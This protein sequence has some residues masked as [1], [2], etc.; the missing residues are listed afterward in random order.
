MRHLRGDMIKFYSI[1]IAQLASIKRGA[2]YV[3]PDG[4]VVANCRL[5]TSPDPCVS[6]AYCSDTMY[7]RRVAND[8]SG[9]DTVYHEATYHSGL[10][11]MAL[12]RG[13]STARQAAETAR[14]AGVNR[15]IIGHFSKRYLH[16]EQLLLDEAAEVFPATVL[17]NEGLRID[18]V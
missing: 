12:E 4:K 10:E 13:H 7:D 15:L 11:A 3:T 2:D 6:Y 1:P 8:I 14:E 17:A 9:V 16:G 5:T 18:L